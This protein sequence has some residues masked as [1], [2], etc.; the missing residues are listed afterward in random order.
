MT[1]KDCEARDIP[2]VS[3]LSESEPLLKAVHE[4]LL[5]VLDILEA[6]EAGETYTDPD[7]GEA[8]RTNWD[9]EVYQ[10][11]AE[12]L[13]TALFRTIDDPGRGIE[14]HVRNFYLEEA[15]ET[16]ANAVSAGDISPPASI[17]NRLER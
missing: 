9:H 10:K 8:A 15:V 5:D 14:D 4:R 3:Q 17:A 13:L 2:D 6:I 1:D 11:E 12:M 16:D 7:L